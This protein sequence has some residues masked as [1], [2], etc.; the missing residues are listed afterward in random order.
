MG[1][2]LLRM[3]MGSVNV[4]RGFLKISTN[5]NAFLAQHLVSVTSFVSV[6]YTQGNSRFRMKKIVKDDFLKNSDLKL[7]ILESRK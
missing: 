4:N 2:T 6:P 1:K 3:N 5:Q 7:F